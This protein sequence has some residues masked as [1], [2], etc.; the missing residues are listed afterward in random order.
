MK[1][2]CY[3]YAIFFILLFSPQSA[4]SAEGDELFQFFTPE[5]TET[6]SVASKSPMPVSRIAANVTVITAEKIAILNAHT[7]AD[8]LRTVPGFNISFNRTPGGY[9]DFSLQGAMLTS[10]KLLVDGV[11]QND[12]TGLASFI[13][14]IPAHN[15]ERVEIIK[16]VASAQWGSALSGIINVITKSPKNTPLPEGAI[17]ASYGKKDTYDLQADAGGTIGR[18]GYYL[19]GGTLQSRGLLP[20]SPVNTKNF[21][22]KFTYELPVNGTATAAF[23][24]VK[25][26]TGTT[27]SPPD[28][29]DYQ[30]KF[31]FDQLSGYLKLA[32]PL[33]ESINLEVSASRFDQ[34]TV[35]TEYDF[36]GQNLHLHGIGSTLTNLIST[37]LNYA[38]MNSTL[39]LSGEYEHAA[40]KSDYI[41]Y[42]APLNNKKSY[43][44][45]GLSANGSYTIG[46]LTI[47]PGLR[48]DRVNIS[49]SNISTMLGATYQITDKTTLRAYIAKGY[50]LPY[51]IFT[52]S[53]Q[54][55]KTAQVG[56]ETT[57][58][59]YLWL[60]GTGF[61]N[62]I[63][64]QSIDFSTDPN[65]IYVFTR[66]KIQGVEVEA[67]TTPLY[68]FSLSSGY[69]HTDYRDRDTN[70]RYHTYPANL[71][72][73]ALHYNNSSIGLK[74]VLTSNYVWMRLDEGWD[75]HSSP[76]V[77][78]VTVTQKLFPTKE[79]SPEV[80]F[81]AHNIFNGAQYTLNTYDNNA[82]RWVEGGVRFKF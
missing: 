1:I 4:I 21:F 64:G 2:K 31:S 52:D 5:S 11:P 13:E 44:R 6:A 62:I 38:G 35:R 71:L 3:L 63:D 49:D 59:N 25:S 56:F 22:S 53:L 70:V 15:I 16:G 75:G 73:L 29:Y 12:V 81:S 68:G 27:I 74:G 37:A 9:T 34:K 60:K 24:M 33:T 54:K 26:N 19:S 30:E 23:N 80:F 82:K 47:L 39:S 46:N 20:N 8:I 42:D 28:Y 65:G 36:S 57:A 78:D 79:L 10:V 55:A 50:G 41:V 76:L 69:T 45:Y 58:I 17:F 18:L 77:T 61:Y 14:L 67:R 32:K 7:L 66:E 72:K 51:A 43:D 40:G 48:Y